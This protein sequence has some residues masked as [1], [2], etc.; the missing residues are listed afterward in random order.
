MEDVDGD[1]SRACTAAPACASARSTWSSVPRGSVTE[2][3]T[4]ACFC[5]ARATGTGSPWVSSLAGVAVCECEVLGVA[6]VCAGVLVAGV[7]TAGVVVD[8]LDL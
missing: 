2:T 5:S 3:T 8:V 4:T 1:V 6:V 7:V